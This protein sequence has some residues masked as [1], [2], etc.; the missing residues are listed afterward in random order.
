MLVTLD[1]CPLSAFYLHFNYLNCFHN[2][3]IK[4]QHYKNID[5]ITPFFMPLEDDILSCYL[6][7]NFL[8]CVF[9]PFSL[10]YTPSMRTAYLSMTDAQIRHFGS[11]FQ[12][13]PTT[14]WILFR[15]A[16]SE[17]LGSY[18][19]GC[20]HGIIL[21]MGAAVCRLSLLHQDSRP[22]EAITSVTHQCSALKACSMHVVLQR[23][24]L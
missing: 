15:K 12:V 5:Q 10:Q 23:E 9:Q 2:L 11:D 14:Y 3:L 8:K 7:A 1:S 13:Q 16:M 4:W 19:E 6:N 22:Y 17:T 18:Q 24:A 21:F 20:L